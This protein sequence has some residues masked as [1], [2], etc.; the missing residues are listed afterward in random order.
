MK[1]AGVSS[2]LVAVMLLT[3]G[4]IAEAQQTGKVPRIGHLSGSGSRNSLSVE[5]FLQ[6]LKD[7]S[8]VKGQNI[9]IDYRSAQG[10]IDRL[11][12]LAEELVR[13]KVDII[14]CAGGVAATAAKKA[15]SAIPI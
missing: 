2:I 11:P 1:Q 3:A 4:V 14:F 8:Y 13:L 10:N 5:A 7:L 9:A 6:G 15:T 12:A